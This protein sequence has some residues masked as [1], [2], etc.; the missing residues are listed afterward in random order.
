[1]LL[2]HEVHRASRSAGNATAQH[3]DVPHDIPRLSFT[4][5]WLKESWPRDN[6]RAEKVDLDT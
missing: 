4:E 2:K 5:A 1:M 6:R 3:A